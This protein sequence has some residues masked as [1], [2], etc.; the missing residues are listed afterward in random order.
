M[1][2]ISLKKLVQDRVV[3]NISSLRVNISGY[4]YV[5]MLVGNKSQNI[6][7]GQKTAELVSNT[8]SESDNILSFLADAEIIQTINEKGETRFKLSK[9]A[10]SDYA[11]ETAMADVFGIEL[12]SGEFDINLFASEFTA[13]EVIS[14]GVSA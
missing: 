9:N 5:T 1:K 6:Y 12:S 4:P 13:K 3:T 8:F 7:F 10:G 11:T 2:K 14:T